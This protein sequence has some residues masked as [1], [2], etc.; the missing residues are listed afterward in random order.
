MVK[1]FK[2]TSSDVYLVAIDSFDIDK[3]IYNNTLNIPYDSIVDIPANIAVIQYLE[4]MLY[5]AG[6]CVSYICIEDTMYGL[7]G[8]LLC[9]FAS[10]D[11]LTYF[12]DTLY[13]QHT[14]TDWLT[15]NTSV[16]SINMRIAEQGINDVIQMEVTLYN[17][18]IE[19]TQK[20]SMK[21]KAKYDTGVNALMFTPDINKK[22]ITSGTHV[23]MTVLDK[24]T[25]K[26]IVQNS[27]MIQ[28]YNHNNINSITDTYLNILSRAS[29]FIGFNFYTRMDVNE[30]ISGEELDWSYVKFQ[31]HAY[32]AVHVFDSMLCEILDM[33]GVPECIKLSVDYRISASKYSKSFRDIIDS[34]TGSKE[35]YDNVLLNELYAYAE[36]IAECFNKYKAIVDNNSGYT[37]EYIRMIESFT[38]FINIAN[39]RGQVEID[40]IPILDLDIFS[41]IEEERTAED[42][43]MCSDDLNDWCINVV[44]STIDGEQV[45]IPQIN[46][47]TKQPQLMSGEHNYTT[48]E[49]LDEFILPIAIYLMDGLKYMDVNY[50][51]KE[52]TKIENLNEYDITKNSDY[53]LYKKPVAYNFMCLVPNTEQNRNVDRVLN[54]FYRYVVSLSCFVNIP[55]YSTNR[56]ELLSNNI[57]LNKEDND[58]FSPIKFTEN[59]LRVSNLSSGVIDELLVSETNITELSN[60]DR[61]M[62]LYVHSTYID[63]I[64]SEYVNINSGVGFYSVQQGTTGIQEI[65]VE[66]FTNKSEGYVLKYKSQDIKEIVLGNELLNDSYVVNSV[67]GHFYSIID[68][69][70]FKSNIDDNHANDEMNLQSFDYSLASYMNYYKNNNYSS[71]NLFD[72]MLTGLGRDINQSGNQ[73]Y[74]LAILKMFRLGFYRFRNKYTLSDTPSNTPNSIINVWD[75]YN[76]KFN[77][78]FRRELNGES[79]Y[80]LLDVSIDLCYTFS[81][82][83]CDILQSIMNETYNNGKTS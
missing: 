78:L 52:F 12:T 77:R 65:P 69:Y 16:D 26:A 58:I 24:E 39:S 7:N 1:L 33:T 6:Y 29:Y 28:G 10:S 66:A 17:D 61:L 9:V 32:N 19:Y 53:L 14:N 55:Y 30:P 67:L 34:D 22:H 37:P 11:L 36:I 35:Y 50:D 79:V 75:Y 27:S 62:N 81:E 82:V 41:Q 60:T 20:Y 63:E 74:Y 25:I 54:L 21:Q 70:Y 44:S 46:K 31:T 15:S 43:L 13:L 4:D 68:F 5:S 73:R 56:V 57:A 80:N 72:C 38:K 2:Y 23:P 45:Y 76:D 83:T 8:G 49:I 59:V 51:I 64:H 71:T 40:L 3:L 48:I 47:V 42:N 18:Y